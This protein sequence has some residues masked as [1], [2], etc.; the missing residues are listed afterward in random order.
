MS[1]ASDFLRV[2]LALALLSVPVARA[3]I[4]ALSDDEL[5]GISG[6]A[7]VMMRKTP[8]TG[9]SAGSTFYRVGLDATL[10]LNLNI[11]KLQLGC[12]GINGPGQCDIDIDNLSLFGGTGPGSDLRLTRPFIE[13]AFKN[14]GN[15]AQRQLAGI[16]FSAQNM[17]G[18]MQAG[19]NTAQP[20]GINTFSGYMN[21]ASATGTATI[22]GRNITYG[23]TG[24][25]LQGNMLG[26]LL[27]VCLP[28]VFVSTD[29]SLNT[30]TVSAPFATNPTVISGTRLTSANLTGTAPVPT[31]GFSGQM[32]STAFLGPFP[33]I[34]YVPISLNNPVDGIITN[35]TADVVISEKLGFVHRI[36]INNPFSL[37]LQKES[38]LWPGAEAVAQRGWWMALSG[39]ID[40]GNVTPTNTIPLD[41]QVARA[42]LEK[43]NAYLQ[44]N[45]L[46]LSDAALLGALFSAPINVGN[47]DLTGERV[48]M[49]LVD[50]QLASQGTV[51]N[52]Y[53]SARFC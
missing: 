12:G 27:F 39:T 37:S 52:C 15:G 41:N 25:A 35:L 40:I 46:T 26:C 16:R 45:P 6:Q 17:L 1:T 48:T 34:G 31:I 14:D 21:L 28:G 51:A 33:L 24:L 11:A 8:G 10:D 44:A 43:V 5:S 53:G 18:V 2:G 23:D 9:V 29:Y 49:P 7:L 32:A 30:Q 4:E 19:Q 38:V 36:P 3:D 50:L 20:N 47:V 22:D 13:L 42:V